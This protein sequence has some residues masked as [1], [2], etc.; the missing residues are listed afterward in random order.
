MGTIILAALG[1]ACCSLLILYV[2][3]SINQWGG[4]KG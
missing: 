2:V 4:P 3:V 1:V